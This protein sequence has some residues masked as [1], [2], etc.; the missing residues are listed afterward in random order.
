MKEEGYRIVIFYLKVPSPELSIARVQE[1]VTEGGHNVP[2]K[3][4]R[5]RFDKSWLNFCELFRPLAD[6]WIV[7]ENS[8]ST[9]FILDQSHE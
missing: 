5:R 7:F 2:E 3:D 1:R 6:K 4:I 9:P 8:G